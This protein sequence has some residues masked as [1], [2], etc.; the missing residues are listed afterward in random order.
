MR[1]KLMK[2]AQLAVVFL[3]GVAGEHAAL[4]LGE[5]EGQIRGRVTEASTGA[6][7]PGAKVSATSPALIGPPRTTTTDEEGGFLLADLPGGVYTVRVTYAG[8]KPMTRKIVVEVGRTAPLNI[9]WSA[10]LAET[11]TTVVP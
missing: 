6:A 2:A 9:A 3:V 7:V 1:L 11:E 4:A 5:S 10:E 8:V